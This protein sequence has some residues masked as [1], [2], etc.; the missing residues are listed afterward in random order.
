MP[1]GHTF[2]CA[3]ASGDAARR[4]Q[5]PQH[6][7]TLLEREP[8]DLTPGRRGAAGPH[9]DGEEPKPVMHGREK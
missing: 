7:C 8:G 4:G 6:A 5:R 2:R 9:G 3:I 1:E